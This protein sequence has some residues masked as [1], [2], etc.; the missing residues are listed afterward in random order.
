MMFIFIIIV[1]VAVYLFMDSKNNKSGSENGSGAYRERNSEEGALEI[2]NERFA[3][4]E[5]DEEEYQS[6]KRLLQNK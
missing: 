3:K 5:I 1:I 2:L 4:G 6:K